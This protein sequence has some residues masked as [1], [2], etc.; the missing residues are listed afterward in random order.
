MRVP[1]LHVRGIGGVAD[2]QRVEQQ[3]R[4]EIARGEAGDD[5]LEAVFAHA[6]QVR[7]LEPGGLPFGV[8]Q[9]RRADLEA[10]VVVR[11]IVRP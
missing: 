1:Q 4:V 5:A 8:G 6:R 7:T 10:I 9:R 2:R 3:H 11:R